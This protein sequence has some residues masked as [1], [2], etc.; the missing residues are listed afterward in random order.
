MGVKSDM[1]IDLR[2]D[3][4]FFRDARRALLSGAQEYTIGPRSV[5]KADL[6]VVNSEYVRLQKEM[7]RYGKGVRVKRVVFL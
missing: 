5:T 3:Y 7:L 6:G 4:A 2:E 1:L